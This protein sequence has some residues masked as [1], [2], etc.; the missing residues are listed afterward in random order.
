MSKIA[1]AV[2]IPVKPEHRVAF[3]RELRDHAAKT[4]SG[5]PGCVQFDVHVAA[6]DP[7]LFFI[8]EVYADT[9]AL[10]THRANPQ[11]ARY[12]ERTDHMVVDRRRKEW[13]VIVG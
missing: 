13:S 5:E 4:H 8:Y 2:E 6:D 10:E 9:A 11:L 3:E 7:N 12:R 1:L